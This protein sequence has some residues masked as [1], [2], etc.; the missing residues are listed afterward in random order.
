MKFWKQSLNAFHRETD[1]LLLI[2]LVSERL[3]SSTANGFERT[4]EE[5]RDLPEPKL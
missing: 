3:R 1:N 5:I 4:L 2:A